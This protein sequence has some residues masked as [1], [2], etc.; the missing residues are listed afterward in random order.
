MRELVCCLAPCPAIRDK[1]VMEKQFKVGMIGATGAV[2]GHAARALAAM[3]EVTRLTLIGRRRLDQLANGK[4]DQHIA[5]V[6]DARSYADALSG[7]DAAV[8]TLGVGQPTKVTRE[9]L[10]RTDRTAVV[11]FARAC[12][13]AGVRHF[14]LLASVGASAVSANFY[15]RTKGELENDLRALH[16]ERLS[17]FH[18]SVIL[19]P[20]NRYGMSQAVL[21]AVM[22]ML[23]P[24]LLGST[25]KYRGI[26]V[27]RLGRAMAHNVTRARIGE[28]VLHWDEIVALCQT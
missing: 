12:K 6:M 28:E 7:L 8:C 14:S 21:L 26:A 5:D 10:V 4:V 27:D 23:S 2:G 25:R 22:P 13:Q 11:D 15:L 19:T 17:L 18:P 20:A 1:Q 9:E 3:P 24:L 16:F